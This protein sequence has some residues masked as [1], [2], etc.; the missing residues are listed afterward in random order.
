MT[1]L[2]KYAIG[3]PVFAVCVVLWLAWIVWP[4]VAIIAVVLWMRS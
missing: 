1:T 2:V 4:L 3:A